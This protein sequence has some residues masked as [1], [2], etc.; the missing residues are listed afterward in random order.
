MH[1]HYGGVQFV[2]FEGIVED[3][4]DPERMG[5]VRVRCYGFHTPDRQ[6]IPTE[7]LHWAL[8]VLPVTA[9][10]TGGVTQ[11]PSLVE[12][13]FVYG[14]FRDNIHMQNPVIVGTINGIG[15]DPDHEKGFSDPGNNVNDRP[16]QVDTISA[17]ADGS[18]VEV[19]E[20]DPL[21]YPDSELEG[22]SDLHHLA[23]GESGRIT[24][25]IDELN[26]AHQ[27]IP[28]ALRSTFSQPGS[29]AS[30][31]Y[32]YNQ[33]RSSE[34]GH[35]EEYDDSPGSERLL[36]LHRTGTHTECT[37]N[38][39]RIEATTNDRYVGVHKDSYEH[40][41]GKHHVTVDKGSK[42]LINADEEGNSLE[43]QV[44][45]SGDFTV[46]VSEGNLN[47]TVIGNVNET[48]EGNVTREVT[49]NVDET[50]GGNITRQ[51]AGNVD[52]TISGNVNETISGNHTEMTSGNVIVQGAT[53][54]LN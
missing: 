3:R 41:D 19:T 43:V 44:G 9:G 10:G 49:G 24:D 22:V 33:V 21:V 26:R 29:N 34:S 39:D 27:Q 14:W 8:P 54:N 2:W 31:T 37:S 13:S 17:P 7:D 38:G 46:E 28:A 30:R 12:G 25:I 45:A 32:P 23:R 52:E 42:V 51:V 18:G 48:I 5:R 35:I 20:R 1:N 40:I 47:L 15:S 50:I 16:K 11:T 4:H 36:W 53:I 6:M